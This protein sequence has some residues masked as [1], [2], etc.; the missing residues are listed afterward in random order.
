MDD[1][2]GIVHGKWFFMDKKCIQLCFFYVLDI[3]FHIPLGHRTL[4]KMPK[5]KV[6]R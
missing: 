2:F 3:I 5:E 6:K 4:F 1:H